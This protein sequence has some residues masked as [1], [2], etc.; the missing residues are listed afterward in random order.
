MCA[1][2]MLKDVSGEFAAKRESV[3]QL[4]EGL[5]TKLLAEGEGSL[6]RVGTKIIELETVDQ[7]RFRVLAMM[8]RVFAAKQLATM[9]LHEEDKTARSRSVGTRRRD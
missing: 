7:T 5:E 4:V 2:A 8:H 9:W 3:R 6:D 1:D